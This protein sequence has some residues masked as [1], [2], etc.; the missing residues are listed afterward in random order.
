MTIRGKFPCG[1]REDR[2]MR[3]TSDTNYLSASLIYNTLQ[4]N[5]VPLLNRVTFSPSR[6]ACISSTSTFSCS[7]RITRLS[8]RLLL[9][10]GLHL[11][12]V[13]RLPT[14]FCCRISSVSFES[15]IFHVMRVPI[16]AISIQISS[17]TA[18][19]RHC[20]SCLS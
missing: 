9:H 3:T 19:F 16:L 11:R 13:L 7:R 12:P 6:S 17:L 5:R 2:L 8:L 20:T 4:R 10:Y 14:P 15:R 18:D 1:R